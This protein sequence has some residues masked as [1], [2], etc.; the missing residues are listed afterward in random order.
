MRF[1]IRYLIK[2]K[3]EAL[4]CFKEYKVL[5]GKY[6]RKP[7]RKVVPMREASIPPASSAICSGKK[8]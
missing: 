4:V 2:R 5:T 6:Y 3:L 1:K 8:E 7:I